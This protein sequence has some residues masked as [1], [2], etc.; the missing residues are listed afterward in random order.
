MTPDDAELIAQYQN[1]NPAAFE[2]LLHRH[3]APLYTFLL[4]FTGDPDR[5]DDLFQDTFLHVLK[6]LPKYRERGTFRHWLFRIANNTA[7][8]AARRE[9][10]RR[11]HIVH[12]DAQV[13]AAFGHNPRP[14]EVTETHDI[15]SHVDA[16]LAKLP[17]EQR[18]VFLLRAHAGM[19]FR[20]IAELENAPLSTI[21]SQMRYAI[22][23]L[24]PALQPLIEP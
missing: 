14:D 15:Q 10:A 17:D 5:A 21:I 2:T 7:R 1:G 12:D 8:D 18:R 24:K 6:A 9:N 23:K 19:R 22:K 11:R 16:A 20:E 13:D 3:K 4:R